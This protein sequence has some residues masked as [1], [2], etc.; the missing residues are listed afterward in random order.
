MSFTYDPSKLSTDKLYQVR[1]GIGDT[2]E[3]A[4]ASLADE[5]INY[6][7]NKNN[8]HV[9]KTILEA[10]DAR[11]NK[12]SGLVDKTTGQTQESASQLIDNL[13]KFRDSVLTSM[14][15]ATPV[16]TEVTGV[17]ESDRQKVHKD[18]EI[19][20]DGMDIQ[21]EVPNAHLLNG[22]ISKGAGGL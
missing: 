15:R 4:I 18:C 20:Q 12:A 8:E 2:E 3:Y 19:F 13:K 9:D 7:L 21:S 1:F 5:E 10:V 22:P 17:I 11:I 16:F 14:L 6:L